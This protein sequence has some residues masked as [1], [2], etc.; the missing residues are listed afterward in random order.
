VQNTR[1]QTRVRCTQAAER[2]ETWLRSGK[3][4]YA[5]GKKSYQIKESGQKGR[6]VVGLPAMQTRGV[7]VDM[8]DVVDVV[9]VMDVNVGVRVERWKGG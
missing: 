5:K 7:V 2:R 8:V 3:W 6:T 9:G 1:V 4:A